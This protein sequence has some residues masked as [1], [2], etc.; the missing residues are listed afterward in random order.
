MS[1]SREDYI[2]NI[3]K[4][5]EMYGYAQNKSLS[6]YLE[7]AKPSVTDMIGKLKDDNLVYTENSKIFLTEEGLKIA[8]K[9]VSIHRLWEKFLRE[10]LNYNRDNIHYQA[11]LL[12]HATSDELFQALNKYL[13]Y[14]KTCPHGRIIY[15]NQEKNSDD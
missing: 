8:K 4:E 10:V 2:K 3:F 12:E 14:P 5:I 7:V 1:P 11:D 15:L 6:Y 13:N 9:L